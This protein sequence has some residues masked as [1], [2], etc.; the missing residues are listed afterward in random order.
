MI[1]RRVHALK[2]RL[3]KDGWLVVLPGRTHSIDL[4]AMKPEHH[5]MFLAVR[6][7]GNRGRRS[8]WPRRS[9]LDGDDMLAL[10]MV[11]SGA[12]RRERSQRSEWSP[13]GGRCHGPDAE[14]DGKTHP[15]RGAGMMG[16]ESPGHYLTDPIH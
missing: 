13:P 5:S 4:I 10:V 16:F 9:G 11:R 3:E 7:G 2:T 6:A 12:Y 8:G 14:L 1:A 15:V